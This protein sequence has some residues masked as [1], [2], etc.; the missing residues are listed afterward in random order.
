MKQILTTSIVLKRTDFGE[1]DRIVTVL[2]PDHGKL[3]LM[4]KG[5]RKLK[6]KMAGGI[7]LFSVSQLTYIEGKSDM[8]TLI[9]SRL[10]R[11][12]PNIIKKIERVQLGY[13]LLKSLDRATEDA[14]EKDYFDLLQN[15]FTAL[16]DHTVDLKLIQLWFTAQLLQ[17]AG[18]AP[19]LRTDTD[20]KTLEPN[21]YQFDFDAMAFAINPTGRFRADHIKTLRLLFGPHSSQSLNQVLG[22]TTLIPDVEPLIRT[23]Q[24]T[25]LRV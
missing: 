4:A 1:A 25:Y 12:Y 8:G 20:G 13:E 19:N 24:T 9:S 7:E 18:H 10:D 16:D 11:H 3:R 21:N 17:L 23:M 2:T 6:S 15:S 5:V 14:P 22:L